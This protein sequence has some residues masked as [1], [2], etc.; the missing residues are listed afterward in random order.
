MPIHIGIDLGSISVKAALFSTESADAAFFDSLEG[1]ELFQS[2]RRLQN[3][4]GGACRLAVTRYNRIA[5]NPMKQT[6][7]LLNELVGLIERSALGEVC[8]TGSGSTLLKY[9]LGVRQRNEFSALTKAVELLHPGVR[10]LF[11][12]GGENSKYL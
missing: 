1:N 10:T 4:S 12:M 5:G 7:A 3:L 2:M 11:E 6:R 8:A 9:E